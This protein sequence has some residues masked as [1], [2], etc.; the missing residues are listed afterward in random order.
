MERWAIYQQAKP[1]EVDLESYTEDP[2]I[3]ADES[4]VIFNPAGPKKFGPMQHISFREDNG[5]WSIPEDIGLNGE[6]PS[7]SP[8]RK[9]LFFIRNDDVYW[10]S[11]KIIE[12]LK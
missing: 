7:L 3:S 4:Y 5:K 9:Y 12:D 1:F 8:D 2:F 10:V 6:L 11:T